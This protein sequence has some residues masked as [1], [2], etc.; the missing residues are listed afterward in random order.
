MA[1]KIRKI[2]AVYQGVCNSSVG[3]IVE[4]PFS[5]PGVERANRELTGNQNEKS[6]RNKK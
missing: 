4:H 2:N 3:D 6:Y 1:E 5:L